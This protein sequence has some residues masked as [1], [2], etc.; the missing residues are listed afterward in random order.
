MTS[1]ASIF[2]ANDKC[3]SKDL[4][5]LTLKGICV[6]L[7]VRTSRELNISY[8]LEEVENWMDLF[9]LFKANK[10]DVIVNRLNHAKMMIFGINKYGHVWG[11]MGRIFS[12]Y[13]D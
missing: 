2:V 9:E 13:D 10:T 8:K 12:S 5:D 7:W 3:V 11:G 6:D 1:R 4:N